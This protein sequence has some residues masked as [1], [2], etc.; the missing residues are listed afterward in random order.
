MPIL[1]RLQIVPVRTAPPRWPGPAAH[2]R[3]LGA[4]SSAAPPADRPA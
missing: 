2:R 4:C 3:R 1:S